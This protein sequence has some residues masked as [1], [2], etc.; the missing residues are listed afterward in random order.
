MKVKPVTMEMIDALRT[1]AQDHIDVKQT[2]VAFR[3]EW[4]D[5]ARAA[6]VEQLAIIEPQIDSLIVRYHAQP[7]CP[8]CPGKLI[9]TPT[10]GTLACEKC[11]ALAL[12]GQR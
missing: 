8:F 3:G 12:R 10:L 1:Q 7:N 2:P 4:W 5:E 6:A 11:K 9:V